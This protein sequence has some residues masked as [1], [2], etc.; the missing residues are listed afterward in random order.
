[1][2][3]NVNDQ[4]K[5]YILYAFPSNYQFA[6]ELLPDIKEVTSKTKML[7]HQAKIRWYDTE[8]LN[9]LLTPGW[10]VS[11]DLDLGFDTSPITGKIDLIS[12]MGKIVTEFQ[13]SNQIRTGGMC[14]FVFDGSKETATIIEE[15][16]VELLADRLN[17]ANIG[18]QIIVVN[19]LPQKNVTNFFEVLTSKLNSESSVNYAIIPTTSADVIANQVFSTM[20]TVIKD[21]LQDITEQ[22]HFLLKR[23]TI[24]STDKTG[25]NFTVDDSFKN[26]DYKLLVEVYTNG[27][28]NELLASKSKLTYG[29]GDEIKVESYHSASQVIVFIYSKNDIE[30]NNYYIFYPK[31]SESNTMMTVSIR[32]LSTSNS[33]RSYQSASINAKCFLK[34][35]SSSRKQYPLR[36]YVQVNQGL[37][38]LL[39]DSDVSLIV[40]RFTFGGAYQ[41]FKVPLSDNGRGSPDITARDGLYSGYLDNIISESDAVYSVY[42]RIYSDKIAL[43]PANFGNT[44]MFRNKPRCCGSDLRSFSEEIRPNKVFERVVNCGSFFHSSGQLVNQKGYSIQDLK[45]VNIDADNRTVELRWNTPFDQ[46]NYEIKAFYSVT[47][48]TNLPVEIKKHFAQQSSAEIEIE[49]PS[50]VVSQYVANELYDLPINQ[51]VVENYAT[52][53]T[54]SNSLREVTI[55][56]INPEEGYYFIAVRERDPNGRETKPSNVVP[57]YM[58]SNVPIENNTA[59]AIDDKKLPGI[60]LI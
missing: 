49:T 1:M 45:L 34:T 44:V 59:F 6:K 39:Y 24:K 28:P 38:G 4:S 54:M 15:E 7:I 2:W 58:K 18:L 51:V 37:N 26:I 47:Q 29:Y 35:D 11:S 12:V 27:S 55:K 8:R 52:V 3:Q 25:I 56:I 21:I 30:K 33:F 5:S 32:L 40:R 53:T 48:T 43:K 41:E 16:S 14:V 19:T 10:K 20:S 23:E 9:A 50:A 60:P 22:S 13:D 46:S 42:A 17:S 57:V 31:T 36:G